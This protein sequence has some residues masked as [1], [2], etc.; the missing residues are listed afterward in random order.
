MYIYIYIHTLL[1]YNI[2]IY[3]HTVSTIYIYYTTLCIYIYKYNIHTYFYIYRDVIVGVLAGRFK[4]VLPTMKLTFMGWVEAP[5]ASPAGL[6]GF[7]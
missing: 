6:R 7:D 1:I 3:I 2:Y 5:E 4:D